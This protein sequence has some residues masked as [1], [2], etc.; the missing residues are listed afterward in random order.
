M[1]RYKISYLYRQHRGELR[2]AYVNL[3]LLLAGAG[4]WLAGPAC[5]HICLVCRLLAYLVFD[6]S[7]TR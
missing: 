7:D 4:G 5:L 6:S 3:V 2:V 1:Y